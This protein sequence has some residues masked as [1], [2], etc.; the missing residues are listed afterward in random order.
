MES[1]RAGWKS[2]GRGYEKKGEVEERKVGLE[3]NKM[4]CALCRTENCSAEKVHLVVDKM[5]RN[6]QG[7]M[8][9][10]FCKEAV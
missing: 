2:E 10:A 7:E 8:E 4:C 5:L 1:P 6:L 9:K 3:N